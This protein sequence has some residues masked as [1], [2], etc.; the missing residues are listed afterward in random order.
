MKIKVFILTKDEE[1][2]LPHTLTAARAFFPE[3]EV[4]DSGSVDS[5]KEVAAQLGARVV[6][7]HYRDHFSAYTEI[8]EKVAPEE[9][10]LILDADM[11]LTQELAEEIIQAAS[12]GVIVG[13][14]P[15]MMVHYG[16]ELRHASL[17][18]PKAILFRGGNNPFVRMGHGE[19]IASEIA[20]S[21]FRSML[22]HDDRKPYE[23]FLQSQA[24]Y[25]SK[26]AER[27]N[28]G[29]CN[30]RDR[31]RGVLPIMAVITAS[32]SYL[33]KSGW[34]DGRGGYLYAIDRA[35]AELILHRH[36]V[37]NKKRS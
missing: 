16:F 12:D 34:R 14:A 10:C 32:V 26:L 21:R 13:E 4:W 8:I 11:Q 30:F 25:G 28:R 31:L 23:R 22:R 24:Y 27:Y 19:K 3:V 33:L 2:N 7:Y 35:I 18:P 9:Y 1:S 5:S 20:V 6:D 36:V 15:I 29:E 17:C 37:A